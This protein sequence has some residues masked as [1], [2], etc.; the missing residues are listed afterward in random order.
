VHNVVIPYQRDSQGG[1]LIYALRAAEKFIGEINLTIVG[2]Y[3]NELKDFR[4][5]PYPSESNSL[6]RDRNIFDKLRASGVEDFIAMYDDEILL[7]PFN[8]VP[9]TIPWFCVGL[10]R[11]VE[12][13][14][15]AVLGP[16]ALNYDRHYPMVFNLKKLNTLGYLDWDRPYG[17]C[18][19][20][21]YGN[22]HDIEHTAGID[23]KVRIVPVKEQWKKWDC[24]STSPMAWQD[25]KTE[26]AEMFPI[27]SKWE[28]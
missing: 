14:T 6:Y 17:Y 9:V 26:V 23:C 27:K 28:L 12:E 24:V 21:L 13:R 5:V 25:I 2:D 4:Y 15:K 10:Y 22:R 1:E 18:I 20:S 8:P 3:P 19:K 11:N 16:E 7:A